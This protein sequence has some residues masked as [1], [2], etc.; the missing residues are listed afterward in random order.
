MPNSKRVR[1]SLSLPR[2][3]PDEGTPLAIGCG[4]STMIYP[5]MR[6]QHLY[7]SYW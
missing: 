6:G 3:T 2:F 1:K 7:E 5:L 4:L